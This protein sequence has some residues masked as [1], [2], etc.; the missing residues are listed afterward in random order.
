MKLTPEQINE[1]LAG[2]LKPN[3]LGHYTPP[4]F[5]PK[6]VGP[7]KFLQDSITQKCTHSGHYINSQHVKTKGICGAPAY[8]TCYGERMCLLHAVMVLNLKLYEMEAA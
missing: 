2:E 7:V 1:I 3:S 6:Q 5:V 4:L 8:L